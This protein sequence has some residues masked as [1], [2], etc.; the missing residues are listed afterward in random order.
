MTSK[1]TDVWETSLQT[2][3]MCSK[4]QLPIEN[5]AVKYELSCNLLPIS[6]YQ[7][8]SEYGLGAL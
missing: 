2:P 6:P 3:A 1:H 4:G 7:Q 5:T 8:I